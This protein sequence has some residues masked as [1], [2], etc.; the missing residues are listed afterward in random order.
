MRFYS[1]VLF[2]KSRSFHSHLHLMWQLLR[3]RE[4]CKNAALGL[5]VGVMSLS[6]ERASGG[7]GQKVTFDENVFNI[8]RLLYSTSTK[9]NISI[10]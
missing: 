9:A 2:D 1:N 7:G 5:L 4:Y 8:L 3:A 10:A 6:W